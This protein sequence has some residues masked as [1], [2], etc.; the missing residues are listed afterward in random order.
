[1]TDELTP[2]LREAVGEITQPLFAAWPSLFAN[3]PVLVAEA[4]IESLALRCQRAE[5]KWSEVTL[6][7]SRELNR[8]DNA[9]A[10]RDQLTKKIGELE[11]DRDAEV[12][13]RSRLADEYRAVLAERETAR[14]DFE[15]AELA[16]AR[17]EVELAAVEEA[18]ATANNTN[19]ELLSKL[20]AAEANTREWMRM[21][22]RAADEVVD[23]LAELSKVT[24]ERDEARRELADFHNAFHGSEEA[25]ERQLAE[26]RRE[27]ERRERTLRAIKTYIENWSEG[28]DAED[29]ETLI[30][31]E[32]TPLSWEREAKGAGPGDFIVDAEGIKHPVPAVAPPSAD[33]PVTGTNPMPPT[34]TWPPFPTLGCS[35]EANKDTARLDKAERLFR[36]LTVDDERSPMWLD[37]NGNWNVIGDLADYPTFRAALDAY[38]EPA[39]PSEKE[40][41]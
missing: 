26:A 7:W 18:H 35:P 19:A 15:A 25:L 37:R 36:R 8:A 13:R 21:Q 32:D 28:S 41:R 33:A 22:R 10:D 14:H 24:F 1:M 40:E 17:A 3:L 39:P 31:Y 34:G 2:E 38:L 27:A 30:V 16:R 11:S 4:A 12:E 9:E 6:A 20:A 29:I 23:Q 5:A